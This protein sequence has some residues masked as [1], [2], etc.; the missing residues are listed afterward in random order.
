MSAPQWGGGRHRKR[1]VGEEWT[2]HPGLG[3]HGGLS[4]PPRGDAQSPLCRAD[5]APSE[6]WPVAVCLRSVF[7]TPRGHLGVR[8]VLRIPGA[9]GVGAL[10]GA[11]W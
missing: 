3:R 9:V 6:L 7:A 11:G 10:G 8:S 4:Q 5:A 2:C 1:G